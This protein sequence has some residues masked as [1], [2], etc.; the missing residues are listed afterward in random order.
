MRVFNLLERRAQPVDRDIGQA[1]ALAKS[2]DT[3]KW[4]PYISCWP[5]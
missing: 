5:G 3:R 4:C 2:L 1:G